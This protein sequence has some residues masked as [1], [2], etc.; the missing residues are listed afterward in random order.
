MDSQIRA[1]APC[2]H[3][4]QGASTATASPPVLPP[5]QAMASAP[6]PSY[7]PN[8]TSPMD[9]ASG[10]AA[11]PTYETL[12]ETLATVSKLEA[13][14]SAKAADAASPIIAKGI[15]R[16]IQG[17][18]PH[19]P[20][21]FHAFISVEHINIP[22]L[23]TQPAHSTGLK[24]RNQY[25]VN[26][27]DAAYLI[28]L[29]PATES[30]LVD[31]FERIL[32][33]FCQWQSVASAK[34]FSPSTP[35]LPCGAS[36][37][38][39]SISQ[40]DPSP[41]RTSS[42]S[43]M[44]SAFDKAGEKGVSLVDKYG[45]KINDAVNRK[46]DQ[47]MAAP[48][49]QPREVKMGGAGTS[50]VLGGARS[51]VGAGAGLAATVSDKASTA[52]GNVIA[53]NKAMKNMREAP[54]ESKRR[55]FHN[56]LFAGLMAIGRV[57]VAADKKGKLII[58]SVGSGAARVTGAKYGAEAEDASRNLAHVA[59]DGYRI[60]RFPQKL[61]ATALLKGAL[62]AAGNAQSSEPVIP[63][64]TAPGNLEGVFEPSNPYSSSAN[65]A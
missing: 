62:K 36:N 11:A 37:D 59:L 58:Q 22:L 25:L 44:Q 24:G 49:A 15:L 57:Y 5:S 63:G 43:R 48:P 33:W 2:P 65:Q 23:P 30:E 28:E 31:G 27:P 40:S 6:Q 26:I 45:A 32:R 29:D 51:V 1:T 54:E 47:K 20:S 38:S 16:V 42:S 34:A 19:T 9:P 53:N 41:V 3:L 13:P 8:P 21:A 60:M 52:V 4:Q 64:Y 17:S 56:T 61:G 10:P 18:I 12:I 39:P 14:K 46:V 55:S 7:Y 35:E 50:K